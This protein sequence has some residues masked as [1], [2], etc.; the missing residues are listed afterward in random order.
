MLSQKNSQL[1]HILLPLHGSYQQETTNTYVGS[2]NYRI[3]ISIYKCP[4]SLACF[5]NSVEAKL[6]FEIISKLKRKKKLKMAAVHCLVS[7]QLLGQL[8]TIVLVNHNK[9][10]TQ[11][12]QKKYLRFIDTVNHRRYIYSQ[13][14]TRKGFK[15][16]AF[17]SRFTMNP[18]SCSF[19]LLR[20]FS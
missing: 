7:Q 13:S 10:K 12:K 4:I 8:L 5:P 9:Q 20:G 18:F 17:G 16:L 14:N 1:D 3:R 2:F 11:R 15:S 19:N 6:F